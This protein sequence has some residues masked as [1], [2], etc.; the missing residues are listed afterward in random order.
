MDVITMTAS[1]KNIYEGVRFMCLS[2]VYYN[3]QLVLFASITIV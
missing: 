2:Q 3:F 1:A